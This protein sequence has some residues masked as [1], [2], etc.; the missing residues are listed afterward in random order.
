[1]KRIVCACLL[2]CLIFADPTFEAQTIDD[3]VEIGYGLAIGDV[4]GDGKVDILLA[5]KK[6]F[7][8]YKNPEWTEHLFLENLTFKDNVCI[9]AEDIDGDGKVEVAV[10][11]QWNPGN[12]TDREQSGSVHYLIRPDDLSKPWTAMQLPHDPTTHRMRWCKVEGKW[13]LLALP[14]HG[15]GNKGG[16]GENG[17]KVTAYFIP[18]DGKGQVGLKVLD[19]SLHATHNF[20][21]VN[22]RILVG[23]KEGVLQLAPEKK[24]LPLSGMTA[25][26]GEVR[27]M[28]TPT[29]AGVAVIEPMHGSSLVTYLQPKAG[30]EYVRAV[31]DDDLN[32]GHAIATGD[33]L[34]L[35]RD[36]VVAG[37]R[38]PNKEK[39]IGVKIYVPEDAAG[40]KWKSYWVDDNGMA[41]EDLKAADLNGDGKLDLIASGRVSKNL[42]IYWNRN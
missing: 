37:W 6:K 17:V 22:D 13:A 14:L 21:H 25:G 10:G 33:F 30:G 40:T 19:D 15:E 27:M 42:K 35:G 38:N 18:V 28:S 16:A 31:L 11:A 26:V 9:A 39:K 3:K 8:W 7:V 34:G 5:D 29:Q 12:T 41:A 4:D 24:M 23:G 20:D 2:P 32:Q 1:M 36:Q